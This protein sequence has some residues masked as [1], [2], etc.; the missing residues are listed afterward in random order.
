MNK[1]RK[2]KKKMKNVYTEKGLAITVKAHNEVVENIGYLTGR[3]NEKAVIKYSDGLVRDAITQGVN[4]FA[5]SRDIRDIFIHGV[6]TTDVVT[7]KFNSTEFTFSLETKTVEL[8]IDR[9]INRLTANGKQT[10]DLEAFGYGLIR[11]SAMV[12][13][14]EREKVKV[15]SAFTNIPYMTIKEM[16]NTLRK[17]E[18]CATSED[19]R[20][21]AH[22]FAP[23]VRID[24]NTLNVTVNVNKIIKAILAGLPITAITY[25]KQENK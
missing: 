7:A 20:A 10:I 24:G 6:P 23:T 12:F 14:N 2:R 25:G 17:F 13:A 22:I 9:I 3:T 11:V 18:I 5:D 15:E 8:P 16:K 4:D 19:I 1:N 21:I